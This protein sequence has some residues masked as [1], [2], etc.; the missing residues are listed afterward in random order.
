MTGQPVD[1]LYLSLQRIIWAPKN[2]AW[3]PIV[4]LLNYMIKNILN[5]ASNIRYR[6]KYSKD[7]HYPEVKEVRRIVK[8]MYLMIYPHSMKPQGS[9][10]LRIH[11]VWSAPLKNE[12]MNFI[13]L[14]LHRQLN[15]LKTCSRCGH[16]CALENNNNKKSENPEKTTRLG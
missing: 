16:F 8:K 15:H 9:C 1:C 11:T 13:L 5:V 10:N 7:L 2:R 4:T 3:I 6:I 12:W 14:R